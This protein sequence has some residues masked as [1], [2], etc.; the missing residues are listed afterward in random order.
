M[1]MRYKLSQVLKAIEDCADYDEDRREAARVARRRVETFRFLSFV[2][3]R[4]YSPWSLPIAAGVAVVGSTLKERD[5]I[6]D[7]W[8][9]DTLVAEA[10]RLGVPMEDC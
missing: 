5:A 10:I 9:H 6:S 1:V 7:Q 4:A 2:E 8:I 3:A